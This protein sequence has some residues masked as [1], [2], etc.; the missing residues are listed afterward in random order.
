M[1]NVR[2]RRVYEPLSAEDGRRVLVDGIWP[3]GV[4]KA[5]LR[6]VLWLKHVAP[7]AA[8]RKWFGHEPERWPEF[9]RRYREELKGNP[10]F[11][12]LKALAAE[13]PLTLLYAARDQ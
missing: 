13:G 5:E 1:A 8:L 2:I 11:D 4:S 9:R 12:E 10:A 3:R 6:D 7:S